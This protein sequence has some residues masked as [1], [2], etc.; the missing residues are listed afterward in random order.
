MNQLKVAGSVAPSATQSAPP[1]GDIEFTPTARGAY[2]VT[3]VA[4]DGAGLS[5]LSES[6]TVNVEAL[7]TV[8][9]SLSVDPVLAEG[10]A[11]IKALVTRDGDFSSDPTVFVKVGG[12]AT[13]GVDYL[14]P[15]ESVLI[16][17]GRASARVKLKAIDAAAVEGAE[18]IVLKLAA[19]PTG[20]YAR[21]AQAK[22]K[23]NLLD[24]D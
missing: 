14:S 16:P 17:A 1:V 2:V 7:L 4:T 24:N 22:L 10:G 15:G 23:I 11:K 21:G 19:S 6:F 18:R 8:N 3:A 9:L 20:D 5:G 13:S 12:T